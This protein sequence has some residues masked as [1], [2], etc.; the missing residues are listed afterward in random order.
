MNTNTCLI[1]G[2][3]NFIL[4]LKCSYCGNLIR[5]KI[6]VINFGEMYQDLIFNTELA[7]KKILFAEHKNYTIFLFVLLGIKLTIFTFFEAAILDQDFN[8]SLIEIIAISLLFWIT[9]IAFTCFL[10]KFFIQFFTKKKISIKNTSALI[11]YSFI[12]FSTSLFVIFPLEIM[13]FGQ[14][15]FSKNPSIFEIN[16]Y[17]AIPIIAIEVII[18]LYSLYLLVKFLNFILY[19]VVNG[20]ILAIIYL[21]L[22][23]FGN[24]ILKII[25][26]AY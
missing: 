19:K 9:F 7:I 1:C 26:G 17:K 4:E 18:I 25:L 13:L 21:M 11:N 23:F 16:I 22:I 8:L 24:Y 20:M 3:R 10:I 14:Y 15:F 5:E 12:Y 2:E 6:P